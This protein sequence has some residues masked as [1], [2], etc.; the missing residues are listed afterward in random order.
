MLPML[1]MLLECCWN[2]AAEAA[3]EMTAEVAWADHGVRVA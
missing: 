1:S 3:P 2:F